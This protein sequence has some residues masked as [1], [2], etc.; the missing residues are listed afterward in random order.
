MNQRRRLESV[1]AL[2]S[3][4]EVPTAHFFAVDRHQAESGFGG[5]TPIEILESVEEVDRTIRVFDELRATQH[6]D[7]IDTAIIISQTWN[8]DYAQDASAVAGSLVAAYFA[9]DQ[10]RFGEAVAWRQQRSRGQFEG[11][12]AARL[13]GMVTS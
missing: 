4:E 7:V 11:Q 8:A 12:I 1:A 10:E 2:L 3:P 6:L 5:V 9:W 13:V